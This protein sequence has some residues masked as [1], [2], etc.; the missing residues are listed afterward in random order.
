MCSLKK[1]EP[2][3]L[4]TPETLLFN[5]SRYIF[6]LYQAKESIRRNDFVVIVEGNMDVI[7]LHQA[8]I[9]AA[10]AACGTAFTREQ[11]KL[12]SKGTV[13][14]CFDGD[15]AGQKALDRAAEIFREF[16][17]KH[18]LLICVH[19]ISITQFKSI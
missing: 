2:K 8:G 17:T 6:G 1:D 19:L 18:A 7:S 5:K 10:V 3:Y 13:Y 9:D 11:A 14:L 4:N 15:G 12:I 16:D